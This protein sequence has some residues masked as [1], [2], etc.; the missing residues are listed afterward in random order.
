MKIDENDN[1]AGSLIEKYQI[2]GLIKKGG[3]AAAYLAYDPGIQD[4]VVLKV[5]E[6]SVTVT[7]EDIQRFKDEATV[8]AGLSK[9]NDNIL[10]VYT[11]GESV[12]DIKKTGER[13]KLHY[14]VMEKAEKTLDDLIDE[15][16]ISVAKAVEITKGIASALYDAH[17]SE[18]KLL[19]RDIKPGNIMFVRKTGGLAAK[20][21]DFGLVKKEGRIELTKSGQKLGTVKYFPPELIIDKKYDEKSE[22]YALGLCLYEMLTCSLPY[23]TCD[24]DVK[25]QRAIVNDLQ[26]LPR[27]ANKKIPRKLQNII[28]KAI[29]KSP[30]KRYHSMDELTKDLD[31]FQNYGK[32]I[33]PSVLKKQLKAFYHRFKPWILGGTSLAMLGAGILGY[34]QMKAETLSGLQ[35][36]IQRTPITEDMFRPN[37]DG[38]EKPELVK[39]KKFYNSIEDKILT[40][41]IAPMI[42]EGKIKD[43]EYPYFVDEKGKWVINSGDNWESGYWP[44]ILWLAY[45]KTGDK[46]FKQWAEKWTNPLEYRKIENT[47]QEIG[48]VFKDSFAKGFD[49]IKNPK[50]RET[51]LIAAE[52]L[53]SRFHNKGEYLQAGGKLNDPKAWLC[54]SIEGMLATDLLWQAYEHTGENKFYDIAKKTAEFNKKNTIR[55]DGSVYSVIDLDKEGK[56]K[57]KIGSSRRYSN[58]TTDSQRQAYAIYGFT[59]AYKNTGDAGFLDTA[60]KT[61]DFYIKA[62]NRESKD[63]VPPWDFNNNTEK[64]KFKNSRS[65]SVGALALIE[66]ADCEPN[67]D[68]AVKYK[69]NAFKI[70][71]SLSSKNYLEINPKCDGLIKHYCW[72]QAY[73]RMTDNSII[74]G[75]FSYLN[76][77]NELNKEDKTKVLEISKCKTAP[78]IDGNLDDLVWQETMPQT[79]LLKEKTGFL[80]ENPTLAYI[81]YDDKNLYFAFKCFNPLQSRTTERDG[82][83][84]RYTAQGEKWN[85][86][87]I[88]IV[89]DNPKDSAAYYNFVLNSI[90]TKYDAIGRNSGFDFDW[91]T[92]TKNYG[93]YWTAEG[94]IPLKSLDVKN[95]SY[96]KDAWKFNLIRN[97]TDE[98][99]TW[100]YMPEIPQKK[101]LTLIAQ[102]SLKLGDLLFK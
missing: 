15:E 13:K 83:M 42:T 97:R 75:D 72:M 62:L 5:L 16:E 61:A 41:K 64:N 57:A 73:K 48:I 78:K 90:G 25:T 4:D 23:K 26:S 8:Q 10:K 32:V 88:E 70:L 31:N 2:K 93:N 22:V 37:A 46:K 51:S 60:R 56:I 54:S 66:L 96:L 28:M 47:T 59:K 86:D 79:I 33:A 85:D 99:N 68:L 40:D 82:L 34:N 91:E 92:K 98:S 45:E 95:I 12:V 52:T 101:D 65:A 89:I 80:S 84:W 50:L 53:A 77:I 18:K 19:H 94:K 102:K 29:E 58:D 67:Q 20:I 17:N 38:T 76:A 36:K 49:L 24:D 55:P 21:A 87:A 39:V 100:S 69:S 71:K 43:G 63:F 35:G 81:R 11:A 6:Q 3:M 27:T 14:I 30:D 7:S 44:G 1:L 9:K 74:G